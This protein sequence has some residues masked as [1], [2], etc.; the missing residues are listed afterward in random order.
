MSHLVGEAW[1]W[2]D[3]GDGVERQA[4]RRAVLEVR[5]RASNKVHHLDH[6]PAG[7]C[8]RLS[9]NRNAIVIKNE[10]GRL[11]FCSS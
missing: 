3:G 2:A 4:G 6:L 8:S 10:G 7:R 5:D 1:H 11:F 9:F